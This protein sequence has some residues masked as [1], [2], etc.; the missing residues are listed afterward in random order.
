[1]RKPQKREGV[2][3][4]GPDGN[5]LA[6]R[7]RGPVALSGGSGPWSGAPY[8]A[9]DRY[10]PHLAMW[11]PYLWSP[12]GELNMYRDR[13][14]SR[15]RDLVRNDGWASGTVTRI[16]DNAIGPLLRPVPKP[17]YKYLAAYTGISAFDMEWAKDF[18]RYVDSMW[19]SW[20]ITDL[21]RYCDA[22]RNSSFSQL[23]RIAFRHKLIDGDALAMMCWIPERIG[24]GKAKYA[25]AIQLIDPD[26]LSNPQLRFDQMSMRGG[27]QIDKY[28]AATG[29]WIRQAHQGD[30]FSAAQSQ[31]WDLIPRETDWGRPIIV[32]D[33]DGDR[34]S[35]H[36][37]GAGIFT[38][39]LQRLKMLT[40]YDET[41]LDA[42]ILNAV[43]AAYVESPYDRDLVASALTDVNEDEEASLL[44]FQ[45]GRRHFHDEARLTIGNARV[46][47]LYPGEKI[48]SVTATRP[49]SNFKDFEAA[50]LR[51]VASGAGVAAEQVSNDWA[52]MN[53]SSAR[54][55]LLEAWKTL[56]RRR[57][58]FND[59][60]SGPVRMGWM[61]EVFAVDEP[62]LPAGAP[63]FIECRGAYA[64]CTWMGPGRGW[65]DPVAEKQGAIL[66]ME[67][68][69]STLE[70]ECAEQGLDFE[71]VLEQRKYEVDRFKELGLEMPDWA[72]QKKEEGQKEPG[73]GPDNTRKPQKPTAPG[74]AQQQP[75][76]FRIDNHMAPAHIPP[77]MRRIVETTRVTKKD[78]KGRILEFE[79]TFREEE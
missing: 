75:M 8:D 41:E 59:H 36:R 65:I 21:S 19:R 55:A 74:G 40:K 11:Q 20:A 61:E 73:D 4:L 66:G 28:G 76:V 3:I 46:P 18:G 63:A 6:R 62:P 35:Q 10:G 24:R 58:E 69:L 77:A 51:N 68:A 29:Y 2:S 34:A 25:T 72:G 14:V 43:F 44:S 38:P 78:E 50:V 70:M 79:K 47:M 71:E 12:D 52:S 5:P 31:I 56:S 26:R 1:M 13:I 54:S 45:N 27:V 30:W 48:N 33:F 49:T 67:A 15:V 39:V 37:G 42:A 57:S 64:R 23:M 9:A 16:L 60:F 17:D 22:Q 53:Y 7:R 32:H